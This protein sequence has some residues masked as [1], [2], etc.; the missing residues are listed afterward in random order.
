MKTIVLFKC[1]DS[2]AE[3]HKLAG[4][5]AVAKERGWNVQMV[6]P[7]RTAAEVQ[8][9]IGFWKPDGVTVSCIATAN[10]LP[11]SVFGPRP[12]VYLGR[13]LTNLKTTDSF[14]CLDARAA[15]ELALRELLQLNL[16]HSAFVPWHEP[17]AWS[18]EYEN[19]F[20]DIMS[21]NGKSFS[22]F[23]SLKNRNRR[24]RLAALA[25]WLKGLPHPVGVFTV[26]DPVGVDVLEACRLAQ[27]VVPRDVIVV[28]NNNDEDVCENATP[29][30]SS[31][32]VNLPQAGRLAAETLATLMADPQHT[33]IQTVYQPVKLIR[34]ASSLRLDVTFR[35][36]ER[37]LELIRREACNGLT[38]RDV[39]K[40][41]PQSRRMAEIKFRSVT[42]QSILAA[43]RAVRLEK[44][45]QLLQQPQM[46]LDAVANFCGYKSAAAFSV[47]YKTE[48]G[49][50]CRMKNGGKHDGR[51]TV[52]GHGKS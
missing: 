34:R 16:R 31:V 51:T 15:T 40:L 29:T 38:A 14:V 12:V 7:V 5:S 10:N 47:F 43:I 17:A 25:R 21:F 4:F 44:A 28:S 6:G 18:D 41:F 19:A 37:A 2:S 32:D 26:C 42:G 24:R 45:Q 11:S 49:H 35:V 9:I 23:P 48:T 1:P 3:R 46:K 8:R 30:L 39:L 22:I 27:L 52:G 13:P 36:V 33:P 20:T 50:T